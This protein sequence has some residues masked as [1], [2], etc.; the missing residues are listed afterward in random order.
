M[1][2]SEAL[3]HLTAVECSV[4]WS[5]QCFS[6][7]ARLCATYSIDS[8]TIFDT[9]VAATRMEPERS[10]VIQYRE[11]KLVTPWVL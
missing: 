9:P 7:S 1:L 5:V 10:H 11:Q 3:K 6:Q 4:A 8:S 2:K